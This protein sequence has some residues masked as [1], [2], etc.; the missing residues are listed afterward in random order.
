[1]G[2]QYIRS[3]NVQYTRKGNVRLI[4]KVKISQLAYITFLKKSEMEIC[5]V[6]NLF[7]HCKWGIC[8]NISKILIGRLVDCG[9]KFSIAV[10]SRFTK[11]LH[12]NHA[13]YF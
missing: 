12:S 11:K 3:K 5:L 6:K 2:T 8:P 4:W 13:A 10:L 9:P 1:M 7:S